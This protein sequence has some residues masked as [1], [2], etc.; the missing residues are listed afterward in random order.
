MTI[1]RS[2]ATLLALLAVALCAADA[3]ARQIAWRAKGDISKPFTDPD[4]WYVYEGGVQVPTLPAPG[5][6]AV[7]GNAGADIVVDDDSAAAASALVQFYFSGTNNVIWATTTNCWLGARLGA[8]SATVEGGL[9]KRGA[10]TELSFVAPHTGNFDYDAPIYVEE[11]LLRLKSYVGLPRP[12]ADLVIGKTVVHE[13]ATLVMVDAD[14]KETQSD[15]RRIL[16]Y[17]TLTNENPTLVHTLKTRADS[18]WGRPENRS[19]LAGVLGPR[20]YFEPYGCVDLV[21]TENFFPKFNPMS[22]GAQVPECVVGIQKFGNKGDARSSIGTAGTLGYTWSGVIFRYLG[23]GETTDKEFSFNLHDSFSG[24]TYNHIP[25]LDGGPHGGV[26]FK[27]TWSTSKKYVQHIQLTG[28]NTVPCVVDCN[29]GAQADDRIGDFVTNYVASGDVESGVTL[30]ITNY[31]TTNYSFHVFKRGTGAWRFN[32]G[33]A[34][35]ALYYG[36]GLCGGFSIEEGTLQTESLTER[37]ELCALGTSTHL[38]GGYYGYYDESK[39][40]DWAF[41]FGT[42]NESGAAATE[43][44]LEHLGSLEA[45]S[46]LRKFV[47]IGNG[48]IK[49]SG[50]ARMLVNDFS[51]LTE[52]DKT[53]TL[54]GANAMSNVVT[55][56]RD[57]NGKVTVAKDGAGLWIL[58]GDQTFSGGLSVNAGTLLVEAP[59]NRFNWLRLTLREC[60]GIAQFAELG[61]FDK[62]G[63]RIAKNLTLPSWNKNDGQPYDNERLFLKLTP[64]QVWGGRSGT[65]YHYSGGNSCAGLF[66]NKAT[67]GGCTYFG[68]RGP[69]EDRM[70]QWHRLTIRLRDDEPAVAKYDLCR[71]NQNLDRHPRSF[72]MEGS[73]DG[74]SWELLHETPGRVTLPD[75]L[76][77]YSDN[78]AFEANVAPTGYAIDENRPVSS[79]QNVQ[80]VRV[81]PGAV[82][83]T[84]Y[85]N[86]GKIGEIR[87]DATTGGGTI[88]GF[89]LKENVTLCVENMPAHGTVFMPMTFE[90]VTGRETAKWTLVIADGDSSRYALSVGA[91]GFTVA[92]KGL[93]VIIR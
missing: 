50:T 38:F 44:T 35:I 43:G 66:D 57:G 36:T 67:S 81:A 30:V 17:G 49:N 83:K 91:N 16:C 53:L 52:G 10:N 80:Y 11:G 1:L 92:R 48:R 71:Q 56:I 58:R 41:S 25:G 8:A 72:M 55:G 77:W 68:L 26:T 79:L 19:I 51:A 21:G 22:S 2:K 54:D 70:S 20:I 46:S 33:S 39:R 90:N 64:G 59:T 37:G 27:G 28:S 93:A 85:D 7:V 14:T 65:F 88:D 62:D 5:D 34:R 40:V 31:L 29:I 13:G 15:F 32:D 63:N 75:E 45:V 74:A 60:G 18:S 69:T 87:I 24:W 23:D 78:S 76:H 12:T 42:T 4:N 89:A 82:L 47:L 6:Q 86:V 61:L 73:R 84:E 9:V 3:G